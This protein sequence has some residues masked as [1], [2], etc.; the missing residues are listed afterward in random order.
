MQNRSHNAA[1]RSTPYALNTPPQPPQQP[2][3]PP[4]LDQKTSGILSEHPSLFVQQK[5]TD[6]LQE[7]LGFEAQT[8]FNVTTQK[9]KK[10]ILMYAIEESSF[11]GRYFLG[12]MHEWSMTLWHGEKANGIPVA[13]YYR[14][15]RCLP[16]ALKCFCYQEI[17]HQNSKGEP[18]GATTEDFWICVPKFNITDA[19][20]R[21]E[22]ILSRPTCI[23][24]M[25][26][27]YCAEGICTCRV[28]F[29]LFPPG[30][31]QVKGNETGKLVKVWKGLAE[32]LFTDSDNFEVNFPKESIEET[33]ARLMGSLFLVNQLYF[34]G[35][36]D[37]SQNRNNV[38]SH[39]HLASSNA[40][41]GLFAGIAGNIIHNTM[42]H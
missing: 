38:F 22:Y 8:G 33:R 1:P 15:F 41:G 37:T 16:A 28:P 11:F 5:T 27:D 4:P 36:R 40:N 39:S 12:S 26:V 29:Y 32:E 7:M 35:T 42:H 3:P 31:A 24:G 19:D 17:Q 23:N 13:S 30:T 34:E 9:D 25:C 18:I 20:G 2:Q 21:L 6:W 10:T 14:P